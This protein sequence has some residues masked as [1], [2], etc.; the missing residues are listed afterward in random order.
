MVAERLHS[1]LRNAPKPRPKPEHLLFLEGDGNQVTG[2]HI[3]SVVQGDVKGTIDG[4]KVSLRSS[5]PF[6]AVRLGYHFE[7]I[8]SGDVMQGPLHIGAYPKA[9]WVAKRHR[10]A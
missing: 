5:L 6:E 8:L 3:G 4:N 9:S 10:Y 2:V 1:V 7:G